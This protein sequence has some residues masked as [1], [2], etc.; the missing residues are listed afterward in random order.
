MNIKKIYITSLNYF[1]SKFI[2]E[3]KFDQAKIMEE[4][5][6]SF[7]LA[8]E[9]ATTTKLVASKK[10]FSLF[11]ATLK[12]TIKNLE[13][14]ADRRLMRA[15][16]TFAL[17]TRRESNKMKNYLEVYNLEITSLPNDSEF[18]KAKLLQEKRVVTLKFPRK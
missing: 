13:H 6:A 2:L 14:P 15:L 8:I 5:L 12:N 4:V 1:I 17:I 3:N 11:I 7:N 10:T 9:S 16:I 18:N